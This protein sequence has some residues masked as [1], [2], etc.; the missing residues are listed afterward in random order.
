MCGGFGVKEAGRMDG[1]CD[2]IV[3]FPSL[4]KRQDMDWKI[5]RSEEREKTYL[6]LPPLVAQTC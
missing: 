4:R 2:G 6:C 5:E 1:E 3:P